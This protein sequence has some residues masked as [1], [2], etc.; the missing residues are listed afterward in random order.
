MAVILLI[1]LEAEGSLGAA[2]HKASGAL[3]VPFIFLPEEG[4]VIMLSHSPHAGYMYMFR[5]LK[6]LVLH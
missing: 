6:Y 5:M 3:R 4:L 2:E 1:M